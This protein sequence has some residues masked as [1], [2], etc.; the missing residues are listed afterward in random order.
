ME[1]IARIV[2]QFVSESNREFFND[3]LQTAIAKAEK[4]YSL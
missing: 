4:A 1:Q 2:E 3:Q